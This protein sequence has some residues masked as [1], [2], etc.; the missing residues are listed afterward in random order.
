MYTYCNVPPPPPPPPP[1]QAMRPNS[2]EHLWLFKFN[3]Q[4][5]EI[6]GSQKCFLFSGQLVAAGI[7]TITVLGRIFRATKCTS[8][9]FHTPFHSIFRIPHSIPFHV[10]F[11]SMFQGR[12]HRYGHG[13]T[14]FRGKK[15]GGGALRS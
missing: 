8:S 13:H 15:G 3:V 12:R 11:H 1:Q 10:P 6:A 14:G 2:R 7:V 4:I 5:I 9:D